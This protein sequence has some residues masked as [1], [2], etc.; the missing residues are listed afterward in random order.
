[1]SWTWEPNQSDSWIKKIKKTVPKKDN[2]TSLKVWLH[3][4]HCFDKFLWMKSS[5]FKRNNMIVIY[6][7]GWTISQRVQV[8]HTNSLFTNRNLL[9]LK[10]T[11]MSAK[12]C[13][14][15]ECNT[16]VIWTIF[17]VLG[18]PRPPFTAIILKRVTWIFFR[19]S[20]SG[21]HREKNVIRVWKSIMTDFDF[22]LNYR[23]NSN[24]SGIRAAITQTFWQT[25]KEV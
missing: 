9:G 15:L 3:N 7:W 2:N 12:F 16:L 4:Y 5:H 20:P 14:D 17:M 8:G 22:R 11:S 13:T 21:F 6:A 19:N 1:M 18:S 23:F 25:V 24:C 10:V